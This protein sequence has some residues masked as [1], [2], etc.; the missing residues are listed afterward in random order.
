MGVSP[1]EEEWEDLA[2]ASSIYFLLR[3]SAR[4]KEK[5]DR[6]SREVVFGRG[7]KEVGEQTSPWRM[8]LACQEP[9]GQGPWSRECGR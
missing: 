4:E 6:L 5:A 2:K 7:L 8:L 9:G 3:V 1:L